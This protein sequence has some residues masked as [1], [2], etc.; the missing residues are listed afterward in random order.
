MIDIARKFNAENYFQCSSYYLPLQDRSI[1]LILMSRFCFHFQDQSPFFHEAVRVL[2]PNGYFIVDMYHYTP[3]SRF[4]F[5]Q[6]LRGG[7]TFTHSCESIYNMAESAGLQISKS[8]SVF[9]LP[10]Y[11]YSF[12]PL[13]LVQWLE[14][15]AD[16]FA[17]GYKSKSYYLLR[18]KETIWE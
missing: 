7:Q 3:R 15:I 11:F 13:I 6:N 12:M 16:K 8:F 14:R 2:I 9:F 18:K 17:P 5:L 10:P 1:H 4:P